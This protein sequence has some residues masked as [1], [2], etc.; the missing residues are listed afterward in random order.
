MFKTRVR[1][2][3]KGSMFYVVQTKDSTFSK[4]ANVTEASFIGNEPKPK[5]SMLFEKYYHAVYFAKSLSK[6]KLKEH[7]LHQLFRYEDMMID[8]MSIY[9]TFYWDSHITLFDR[10][11]L[12]FKFFKK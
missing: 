1:P 10:L 12:F 7:N 5:A 8:Y 9:A 11:K 4:W 2:H 3:Y 6:N